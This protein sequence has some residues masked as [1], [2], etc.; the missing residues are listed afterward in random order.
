M[1][2][3]PA[4]PFPRHP[5]R[6]ARC[7]APEVAQ[8]PGRV[9]VGVTAGVYTGLAPHWQQ[10]RGGI[11][12]NRDRNPPVCC[13]WLLCRNFDSISFSCTSLAEY[14]CKTYIYMQ[15]SIYE[16]LISQRN[17]LRCN[18]LTR[19]CP[20]RTQAQTP[21][22][23]AIVSAATSK[24]LNHSHI[25]PLT[26]LQPSNIKEP[27]AWTQLFLRRSSKSF[28]SSHLHPPAAISRGASHA[29]SCELCTH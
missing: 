25:F 29:L 26:Q 9:A 15:L 12:K 24:M 10:W 7:Q 1:H 17:L 22:I 23:S 6:R 2:P 28:I 4:Q 5:D 21:K 11:P 20:H 14:N 8:P 19:P 13:S 18:L 27:Q 16:V 3:G